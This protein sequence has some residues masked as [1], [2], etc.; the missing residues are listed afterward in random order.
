MVL[1]GWKGM[2][3]PASIPQWDSSPQEEPAAEIQESEGPP[4][5]IEERAGLWPTNSETGEVQWDRVPLHELAEWHETDLMDGLCSGVAI[6]RYR[7]EGGNELV[8]PDRDRFWKLFAVQLGWVLASVKIV[9]VLVFLVLH[10]SPY[11]LAESDPRTMTTLMAML[12]TWAYWNALRS[13]NVGK[14]LQYMATFLP[15]YAK[16]LRDGIEQK[17]PAF[18][19]VPGDVVILSEDDKVPADCRLIDAKDLQMNEKYLSYTDEPVRK[20][21][22]DRSGPP[23]RGLVTPENMIFAGC[24]VVRGHARAIVVS[25][26]MDLRVGMFIKASQRFDW[27]EFTWKCADKFGGVISI[28]GVFLMINSSLFFMS[29]AEFDAGNPFA[30]KVKKGG[31]AA[32]FSSNMQTFGGG[33]R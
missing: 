2:L 19:L 18:C 27:I 14:S 3:K 24:P 4:R 33:F 30:E 6:E 26:G 5:P 15:G 16:V 8:I 29:L 25:T 13:D 12:L 21:A 9:T 32:I 10:L 28:T 17:I 20:T 23:P 31:D 22:R 11:E 1:D 7:K